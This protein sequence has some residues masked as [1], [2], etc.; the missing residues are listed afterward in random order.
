[1]ST[2]KNI[3]DFT[4]MMGGEDQLVVSAA[5]YQMKATDHVIIASGVDN[6]VDITLPPMVE[7]KGNFYFIE[8]IDVTND[9]SVLVKETATEI[10]TYGD[11]DTVNDHALFYCSGRRW[12][13]VF[14]GVA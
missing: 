8:A 14:D 13:T 7:A 4:D 6:T 12:I 9:V 5:T 3:K 11:M 1:M 10:A 2:V